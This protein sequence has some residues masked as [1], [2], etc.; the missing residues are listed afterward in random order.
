VRLLRAL[1]AKTIELKYCST[2]DSTERGNIGPSIDAAFDELGERFTVALPALPVNGRT[3]YMGYHFVHQQMLS[4]SPMRNHPLNPMTNPNLVSH[5][6]AQTRHKVGLVAHPYVRKGSDAVRAQIEKLRAEGVRV[7]I[8]DCIGEKDLETLCE[9]IADLPLITGS[10]APAMKL[11][12]K[13]QR[14]HWWAPSEESLSYELA[15]PAAGCLIVA[16][17]CSVAT[18]GQN[19]WFEGKGFENVV[20][21]VVLLEA[22][23]QLLNVAARIAAGEDCLIRT[24]SQPEDIERVHGWAKQRGV[25]VAEAGLKLSEAMAS[26]ARAIIERAMP[27]G[28]IVAGGETAGAVCRRLN[29]GALQVG[30]NIE[31]GVPLCYSLGEF[32]LPVVLKSGNFGSQDFYGRAMG[33]M[34]RGA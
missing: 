19:A 13:W 6:Q 21:P 23:T 8:L 30:R 33:A 4:D 18:R 22:P 20:D 29:L 7:A 28:L 16:G 12:A 17:S 1:E 11:P 31:P 32:Q 26:L 24:A 3:T 15:S 27:C 34:R 2:F 14:R 5:L 10:S 25:S 9:A